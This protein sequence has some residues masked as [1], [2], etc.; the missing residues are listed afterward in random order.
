[1]PSEATATTAF[2]DNTGNLWIGSTDGAYR[3]NPTNGNMNAAAAPG[4]YITDIVQGN[5]NDI[6]LSTRSR[7]LIQIT[8]EGK[9]TSHT[10]MTHGIIALA[11]A[12]N[13]WLWYASDNGKVIGFNHLTGEIEDL[14]ESLPLNGAEISDIA[15][16]QFGHIW[17]KTP[18]TLTEYNP[19]NQEY[20]T[21]DVSHIKTPVE[22]F[23]VK[24]HT[25]RKR[26][27][28]HWRNWRCRSVSSVKLTRQ[29][30]LTHTGVTNRHYKRRKRTAAGQ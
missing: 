24:I 13:G 3:Y 11:A 12:P 29:T 6:W 17:I 9:T 16:D 26:H 27:P 28:G 10:K 5:D 22:V 25:R 15:A 2:E 8:P 7:G 21:H 30:K 14:S 4:C 18:R 23:S 20:R 1:M 19:R